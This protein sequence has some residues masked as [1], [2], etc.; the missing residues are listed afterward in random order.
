[1]Y[2]FT[3]PTDII[4]KYHSL[5]PGNITLLLVLSG[6]I[7]VNLLQDKL[8]SFFKIRNIPHFKLGTISQ[9]SNHISISEQSLDSP[10][11]NN[12]GV[13][14]LCHV[15]SGKSRGDANTTGGDLVSYPGLTCPCSCGGD[16]SNDG[17]DRDGGYDGLSDG[18]RSLEKGF[19]WCEGCCWLCHVLGLHCASLTLAAFYL[20]GASSQTLSFSE[21]S[22]YISFTIVRSNEDGISGLFVLGKEGS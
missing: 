5:R 14:N 6:N 11:F 13:D 22:I 1:M 16:D 19:F 8:H 21:S 15:I 9:E 7:L 2:E 4:H 17:K 10:N 12:I 3:P 20:S 18:W